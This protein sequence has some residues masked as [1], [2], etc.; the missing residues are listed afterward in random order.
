MPSKLIYDQKSNWLFPDP[1]KN[2]VHDIDIEDINQLFQLMPN[3][4]QLRSVKIALKNAVLYALAII[5]AFLR[6]LAQTAASGCVFCIDIIC[7]QNQHTYP[8]FHKN[9][10]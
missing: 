5:D 3:K 9:G 4:L 8:H 7:D 10:G 1:Q 2:L 6:Y